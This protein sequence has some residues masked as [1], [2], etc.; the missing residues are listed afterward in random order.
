MTSKYWDRGFS[1]D[2]SRNTS[3][4]LRRKVL[5]AE[6]KRRTKTADWKKGDSACFVNGVIGKVVRVHPTS[7]EIR[8]G[9]GRPQK[10]N[11]EHVTKVEKK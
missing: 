6:K 7:L 5:I 10:Y 2:L 1:S 8:I 4:E 9:L 11:P 3:P